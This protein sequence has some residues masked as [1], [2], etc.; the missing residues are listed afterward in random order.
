MTKPEWI[1]TDNIDHLRDQ[2]LTMLDWAINNKKE[3]T[4]E[5]VIKYTGQDG[6]IKTRD[7]VF[8]YIPVK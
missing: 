1:E 2:R 7:G 5:P 6:Y 4:V 8:H 3:W